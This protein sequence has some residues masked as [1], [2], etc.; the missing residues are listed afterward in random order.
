MAVRLVREAGRVVRIVV[1]NVLALLA[2]RWLLSGFHLHGVGNVVLAAFLVEVP[3]LAWWTMVRRFPES[4]VASRLWVGR[5]LV[6]GIVAPLL[7]ATSLPGLVLA[8]AL[9]QLR[10][11]GFWTYVGAS[12][13]V[14]AVNLLGPSLPLR[15][16]RNFVLGPE[17]A[18]APEV[19]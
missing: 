19:A 5:L 2:C 15:F 1:L 3:T 10:I 7:L 8:E 13:I 6:V 16:V 12:A 17:A 4:D 9:S 14:A 18:P 11:V